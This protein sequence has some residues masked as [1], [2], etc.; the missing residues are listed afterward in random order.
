MG[1]KLTIPQSQVHTF[2][3]KLAR[4]PLPRGS[5]WQLGFE[6]LKEG[7]CPSPLTLRFRDAM[8]TTAVPQ[9]TLSPREPLCAS[10]PPWA[11]PP[12]SGMR[13]GCYKGV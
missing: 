8:A 10:V 3:S 1:L 6:L 2:A 7:N 9:C 13:L 12:E 11:P 5:Y 4:C